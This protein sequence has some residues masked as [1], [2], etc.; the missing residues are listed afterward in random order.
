MN[1]YSLIPIPA[2]EPTKI[3]ETTEETIYAIPKSKLISPNNILPVKTIASKKNRYEIVL[4]KLIKNRL[5]FKY[6]EKNK[7]K[8]K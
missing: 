6:I 3:N 7:F 5:L 4:K 8:I 1:K 2:G